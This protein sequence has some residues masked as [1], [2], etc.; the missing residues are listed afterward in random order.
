[1]GVGAIMLSRH[2]ERAERAREIF[3]QAIGD[4]GLSVVGWREV[5]VDASC[6][7][8]IALESLPLFNHVFVDSP[9]DLSNAEIS[10]RL[11]MARRH[12]EILL[13]D[14]KAFYVA[15]LSTSVLS[16]KGLMMPVDL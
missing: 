6:L 2:V 12:A 11:M 14:D 15:S 1:Y 16:Y 10:A 8:P 4:Q 9:D 7:G 3:T 13:A 5:P